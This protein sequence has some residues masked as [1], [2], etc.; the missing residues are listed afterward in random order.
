MS[1]QNLKLADQ[2]KFSYVTALAPHFFPDLL[3]EPL[4]RFSA[5]TGDEDGEHLKGLLLRRVERKI[6]GRQRVVVQSWSPNL[7]QGQEAGVLQHLGKA[8]RKLRDLQA[9][10]KRRHEAGYRGRKP[11]GR[12][13]RRLS[14]V[15]SALLVQSYTDPLEVPWVA[16]HGGRAF[17][18]TGRHLTPKHRRPLR[19]VHRLAP[20]TRLALQ[21]YVEDRVLEGL[22]ANWGRVIRQIAELGFDLI[23]APSHS[24]WRDA[25][26]FCVTWNPN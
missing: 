26:R 12:R 24:V 9:S 23:L 2:S 3:A 17:G 11:P 16:L 25:P 20:T 1:K 4:S 5:P 14:A 18:L 7:A 22:W 19:E 13:S 15:S 10:L 8:E 21:F 6:W